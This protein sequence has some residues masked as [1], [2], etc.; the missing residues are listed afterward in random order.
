MKR[1]NVTVSR[2]DVR[3][4]GFKRWTVYAGGKAVFD[5]EAQT[6]LSGAGTLIHVIDAGEGGRTFAAYDSRSDSFFTAPEKPKRE[7]RSDLPQCVQAMGCYY[8]GHARGNAVNSPCD[9]SEEDVNENP[10]EGWEECGC[11]GCWH[12]GD[13][14][15]YEC[16]D[17]ANRWPFATHA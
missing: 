7:T 1:E 3:P 13:G 9:T 17:D 6:M 10:P 5:I 16:R 15:A 8:A 14:K 11:C 2:N 4:D 12:P